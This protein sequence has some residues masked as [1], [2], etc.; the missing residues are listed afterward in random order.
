MK[1]KKSVLDK[2]IDRF[3]LHDVASSERDDTAESV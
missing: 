1:C 3:A 2:L